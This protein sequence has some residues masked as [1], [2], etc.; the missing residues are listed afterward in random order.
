[1][2]TAT[3]SDDIKALKRFLQ[4]RLQSETAIEVPFQV[5]CVL[6]DGELLILVQHE[7]KSGADAESI[8]NTLHQAISA[9]QSTLPNDSCQFDEVHVFLRLAG[10]KQPYAAEDFVVDYPEASKGSTRELEN[11]LEFEQADSYPWEYPTNEV[12]KSAPGAEENLEYYSNNIS[13][14]EA[15]LE[16]DAPKLKK[17]NPFTATSK[18]PYNKQE[19]SPAPVPLFAAVAVMAGVLSVATIYALT[20]PCV[21]G[22]CYVVQNSQQLNQ[23]LIQTLRGAKSTPELVAAQQKLAI[24]T[25]QLKSIPPWSGD[26]TAAEKLL[27]TYSVQMNRLDL[28]LNALNKATI[29]TQKSQNPPH[30]VVEWREILSLWNEA[31]ALLRQV[32]PNSPV[33]PLVQQRLQDYQLN[34]AIVNQRIRTEQQAEQQLI[35]AKQTAQVATARMGNARNFSNWQQVYSSWEAAVNALT[36]IPQ[37]TMAYKEAQDLLSNYRPKL[38]TARDRRAQE[39]ISANSYNQAVS[40]SSLAQRLEQQ[41][42]WSGAVATWRQASTA[43]QQVPSGTFYYN[44]TQPLIDLYANALKQAEANLR[45]SLVLQQARLDLNRT[46]SGSPRICNFTVAND[47]IKIYLT[48]AYYNNVITTYATAD[49]NGD[50]DTKQAVNVHRQTLEAALEAISENASLPL[51]VYDSRRQ[52]IGKYA[53]NR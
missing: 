22:S 13:Q 2:Q 27:Q 25:R 14:S 11:L 50:A 52:I 41:N 51:I 38:A 1:M 35:E 49:V 43:A 5:Q 7:D 46:C 16:V 45:V 20:R 23:E 42:Q 8:F 39:Q 44:Q 10:Q 30:T 29:A 3:R 12:D 31:I 6:K 21:V 53:P 9:A 32:A 19:T 24:A 4:K 37:S 28:V 47:G 33:Y 15:F 34:V 40:L 48:P 17:E 18:A 36:P 26:R